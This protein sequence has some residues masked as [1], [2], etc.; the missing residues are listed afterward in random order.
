MARAP[1]HAAGGIVVRS[2][3]KTLIAVVQ[4]RKDNG[5]VLPK[6]KLKPKEKPVVA[7]KRE[8]IEETGHTVTVHEFLGAITYQ[9]G[10]RAKIVEFWRMEAVDEQVRPLMR[11]IKA[12]AWLTLPRAIDRLSHPLEKVFLRNVGR[13]A[14]KSTNGSKTDNDAKSIADNG[15]P[16]ASTEPAHPDAALVPEP[17]IGASMLRRILQKI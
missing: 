14:L 17:E 1:I 2:G 12:V 6:G 10:A 4:R 11:D 13:R 3:S 5:W 7:A 15:R 8:A 16:A 9:A